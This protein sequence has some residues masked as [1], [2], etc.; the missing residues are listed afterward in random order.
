MRILPK[1]VKDYEK[2]LIKAILKPYG[3]FS[4]QAVDGELKVKFSAQECMHYWE[5]RSPL[6]ELLNYCLDREE[7]GSLELSELATVTENGRDA[8]QSMLARAVNNGTKKRKLFSIVKKENCLEVKSEDGGTNYSSGF[9]TLVETSFEKIKWVLEE[10]KNNF[11]SLR[12]VIFVFG[13]RSEIQEILSLTKK[14]GI[15]TSIILPLEKLAFEYLKL[16]I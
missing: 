14:R 11:L 15:Q 6:G 3:I 7:L 9:L 12:K 8:I 10:D 5:I 4:Y 13:S 1:S 16:F 2:A